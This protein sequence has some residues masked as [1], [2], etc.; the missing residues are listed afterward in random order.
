[1][2]FGIDGDDIFSCMRRGDEVSVLTGKEGGSVVELQPHS[3]K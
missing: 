2:G 1:M 3:S